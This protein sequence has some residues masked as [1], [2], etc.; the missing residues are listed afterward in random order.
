MT[1]AFH[2]WAG[3]V[4][5]AVCQPTVEF[6]ESKARCAALADSIHALELQRFAQPA[7]LPIATP[8]VII[9]TYIRL[10]AVSRIN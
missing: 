4:P 6:S 2:A 10:R 5:S 8:F 7:L 1:R 3:I 9:L